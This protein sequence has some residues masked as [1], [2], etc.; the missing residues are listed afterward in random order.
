MVL[1]TSQVGAFYVCLCIDTCG[2]I[3]MNIETL[4]VLADDRNFKKYLFEKT[5][6]ELKAYIVYHSK[7]FLEG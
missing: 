4:K 1:P 3:L 6:E 7:R 5:L 2:G